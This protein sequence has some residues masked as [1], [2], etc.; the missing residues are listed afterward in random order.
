MSKPKSPSRRRL[1][2]MASVLTGASVINNPFGLLFESMVNGFVNKAMADAGGYDPRR[3]IYI[4]QPGAPPRWMFDLFLTPYSSANFIDNPM[5][6]TRYK[7]QGGRYTDVEYATVKRKGIDVPHMWQ[8]DVP[9]AGG[10][11]RP[12]TDLL[13]NLL[14]IQGIT[15]ENAGH[16][17]SQQLHF[18]P[19][20]AV[21]SL[22]ALTG[23]AAPTPLSAVDLAS[24]N[25]RYTSLVGKSSVRVAGGGNL[26]QTLLNPFISGAPQPFLDNLGKVNGSVERGVAALDNL[27]KSNHPAAE[28]INSDRKAAEDLLKQGFPGLA[29]QWTTLLNKYR[30]LI[31]RAIDPT[32]RLAGINALPIG[33]TGSRDQT[34]AFGGA[35][36]VVTAADVR[37]L[38]QTNTNIARMAEH[39]A[40][41]EYVILNDLSRSISLS[42]GQMS[43]LSLNGNTSRISRFDEHNT[44]KM[45]TLYMNTMYYRALASCVLELIDQLKANSLFNDTVI[46]VGGEFNRSPRRNMFGSDHGWQGASVTVYSG[47]IQGPLIIGNLLKQGPSAAYPGTWGY[48]GG[49]PQLAGSQVGLAH[50]GATMGTLLRAPSPVTSTG[51]LV[52]FQGNDLQAIIEKTKIV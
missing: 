48:G 16:P 28:A 18:K 50:V 4:Q 5:V 45:I 9:K 41:T 17:G 40:V 30:D 20:G 26:L 24:N 34:Y 38:I 44:G 6:G 29:G 21:R 23:D 47:A 3:Y 46:D 52:V 19:A 15:T 27:A 12:M 37:S 39:F 22:P 7:A 2:G 13:D 8:F 36:N 32:Q 14:A 35:A 10:G 25:Y 51:P 11:V 31:S 42:L 33:V 43:N 1:L 49:V